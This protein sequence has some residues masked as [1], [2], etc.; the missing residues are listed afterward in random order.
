MPQSEEIRMQGKKNET[1]IIY[2]IL[3]LMVTRQYCYS[4]NTQNRAKSKFKR[5][6]NKKEK[7]ET[8]FLFKSQSMLKLLNEKS[9][10]NR[11]SKL[12]KE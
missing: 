7:I 9:S 8:E 2:G 12:T 11:T 1:Y 6:Q 5:V 3:L 4:T 10:T